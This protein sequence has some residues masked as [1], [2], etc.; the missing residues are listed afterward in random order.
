MDALELIQSVRMAYKC[1]IVLLRVKLVKW[2]KKR[3]QSINKWINKK[4]GKAKKIW[5]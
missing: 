3:N 1:R 5:V 2:G 4:K